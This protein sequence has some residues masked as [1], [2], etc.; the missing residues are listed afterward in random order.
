MS[1]VTAKRLQGYEIRSI[2]QQQLFGEPIIR[3]LL[4]EKYEV[5][6]HDDPSYGNGLPMEFTEQ[7]EKVVGSSQDRGVVESQLEILML[8]RIGAT[9]CK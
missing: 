5:D 3:H 2:L 4:I 7:R 6:I 8:N 1:Y 9:P